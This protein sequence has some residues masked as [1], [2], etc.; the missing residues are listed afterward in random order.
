MK[1]CVVSTHLA[2][3][4]AVVIWIFIDCISFGLYTVLFI[5]GYAFGMQILMSIPLDNTLTSC[6]GRCVCVCVCVA[7]NEVNIC[8]TRSWTAPDKLNSVI[9]QLAIS[10][11]I[12]EVKASLTV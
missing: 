8:I 10:E 11:P 4:V 7:V 12:Q 6:S 9:V 5:I 2:E 1:S 3:F